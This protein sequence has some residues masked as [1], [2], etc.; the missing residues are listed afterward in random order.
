MLYRGGVWHRATRDLSACLDLAERPTE[1]SSG[2]LLPTTWPGSVIQ[3]GASELRK[4]GRLT[5]RAS[6]FVTLGFPTMETLPFVCNLGP[7]KC[8]VLWSRP[9]ESLAVPRSWIIPSPVLSCHV[10]P[11]CPAQPS[12]ESRFLAGNPW[13][14]AGVPDEA[15]GCT[16]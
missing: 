11:L 4:Q 2:C 6:V 7:R 1:S 15:T 9:Q 3:F 13:P 12:L 8:V 5:G 10:G 16:Y 14:R